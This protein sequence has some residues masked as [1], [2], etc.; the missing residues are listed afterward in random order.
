VHFFVEKE[1]I[2]KLQQNCDAV[3]VDE[4]QRGTSVLNQLDEL[5]QA[6]QEKCIRIISEVK[7]KVMMMMI[8]LMK[9]LKLQL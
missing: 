6:D 4:D 5:L 8:N 2:K 1:I 3:A 7:N 9:I